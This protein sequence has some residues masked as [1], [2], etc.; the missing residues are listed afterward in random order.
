VPHRPALD[1]CSRRSTVRR[2]RSAGGGVLRRFRSRRF[3]RVDALLAIECEING[4][5]SHER[6]RVLT[7]D[8][9]KAIQ[10]SLNRGTALT[11][12]LD[13]G[14]MCMSNN[15]AERALRGIAVG[16]HNWTLAGSDEGGQ[17]AAAIYTLVETA[18]LNHID[19]QAWLADVLARLQDYPARR[20]DELLS[21]NWKRSSSK[22]PPRS[23]APS[24]SI[25][26]RQRPSPRPSPGR[27]PLG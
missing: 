5:T 14:H 13:D 17:R 19:P 15:A 9:A 24:Q 26:R 27:V 3:E 18:K 25:L 10:Y 21:S 4:A 11:C 7:S 8:V 12:F 2:Q 1:L 6:K 16:R 20:I 23:R 22:R